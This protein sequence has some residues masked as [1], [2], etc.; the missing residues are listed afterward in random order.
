MG[1][2]ALNFDIIEIN[3]RKIHAYNQPNYLNLMNVDKTVMSTKVKH[4]D[5]SFL[6]CIGYIDDDAARPLI[7]LPQT[8]GY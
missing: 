1:R 5:K 3:R 6:N 4:G 7:M 2:K 8:S